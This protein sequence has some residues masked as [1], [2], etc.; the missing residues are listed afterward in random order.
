MKVYE[1]RVRNIRVVESFPF[2]LSKQ[3]T[4]LGEADGYGLQ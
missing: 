1:R 2:F 3:A 4:E